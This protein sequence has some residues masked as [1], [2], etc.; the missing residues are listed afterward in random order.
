M[1]HFLTFDII[2][3][4]PVRPF[5]QIIIHEENIWLRISEN[6]SQLIWQLYDG[7]IEEM[8]LAM[9]D[10]KNVLFLIYSDINEKY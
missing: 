5:I 10:Y 3:D 1:S 9:T 2:H 4:W 8:I 6:T 7:K